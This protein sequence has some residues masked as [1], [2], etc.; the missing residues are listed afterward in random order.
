[1]TA[2]F[3]RRRSPSLSRISVLSNS[4]ASHSSTPVIAPSK[5]AT[6]A[7]V[8]AGLVCPRSVLCY[9]ELTLYPTVNS[10]MKISVHQPIAIAAAFIG[11]LV[12]AQ[13]SPGPIALTTEEATA[14]IKG[15]NHS[16]TRL[17]GGSP[18][19][20]FKDDGTMYGNDSGSSDSGKWRIE[21]G[22]LC[23]AWRRWEYE[24]CGK[25]VKVAGEIQHLYPN[26]TAVHLV[27][28]K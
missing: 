13:N 14:F 20:Q 16:S 25:L 15:K 6:S 19:L 2:S 4:L 10:T 21:D 11:S 5:A 8:S 23:M 12:C 17:A 26:G 9:I 1:M 22:K 28:K 3:I 18:S 24:G 7:T 27:F